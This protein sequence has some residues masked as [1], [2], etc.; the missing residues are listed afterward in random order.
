MSQIHFDLGL[1]PVPAAQLFK[2]DLWLAP[3]SVSLWD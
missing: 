3:T 2:G 1:I